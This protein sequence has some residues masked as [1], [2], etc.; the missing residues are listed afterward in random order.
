MA[1]RLN[2]G[3][4][5]SKLDGY[6]NVDSFPG[7]EPDLLCDLERT[8][9]PLDD[10]SVSEI[11][12]H[13]VLKHLGES[14]DGFFA[15]IKEIYRVCQHDGHL[16]AAVPHPM[17]PTFLSDPTHVRGF[18]GLTFQTLSRKNCLNWT[19]RRANIT[20]VAFMLDVAFEPEL[21]EH[22]YDERW[23]DRLRKGL[24]SPEEVRERA[25]REIGVIREIS[26]RL[27]IDKSHLGRPTAATNG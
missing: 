19:R 17:H 9:W 8:P 11:R 24:V 7:C 27:R 22:V 3:C 23:R 16:V 14:R 25:T 6:V 18:T 12:A 21:I 20:P 4:G 5:Y 13:H 2:I 1:T 10:D 26:V 15:I